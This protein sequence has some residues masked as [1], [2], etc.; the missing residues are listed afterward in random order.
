MRLKVNFTLLLYYCKML[1]KH[2]HCIDMAVSNELTTLDIASDYSMRYGNM[3]P[4]NNGSSG[5]WRYDITFSADK[6]LTLTW[7]FVNPTPM[8]DDICIKE[9]TTELNIRTE[10]KRKQYNE[11]C[12]YSG[13]IRAVSVPVGNGDDENHQLYFPIYDVACLKLMTSICMSKYKRSYIEETGTKHLTVPDMMISNTNCMTKES[14]VGCITHRR[15]LKHI[16]HALD[17]VL[18]HQLCVD[19]T[20]QHQTFV[21]AYKETKQQCITYREN[22]QNI[23]NHIILHYMTSL[24]FPN[25][26]IQFSQLCH[27]FHS[28]LVEAVVAG[29]QAALHNHVQLG[30]YSPEAKRQCVKQAME[31]IFHVDCK[32]GHSY[33]KNQLNYRTAMYRILCHIMDNNKLVCRGRRRSTQAPLPLLGLILMRAKQLN[34]QSLDLTTFVGGIMT[35]LDEMIQRMKLNQDQLEALY[36][37]DKASPLLSIDLRCR[38]KGG[39]TQTTIDDFV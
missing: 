3:A 7:H 14:F 22:I 38:D 2:L 16:Y 24:T 17:N 29:L 11:Y 6:Q 5:V 30:G 4:L 39:W 28:S 19:E 1:S 26:S 31:G 13:Y 36:K 15:N 9:L 37:M 21:H 25:N 20:V 18:W 34:M 10:E 27:N 35:Q 33:L 23:S 12:P 8:G 32:G